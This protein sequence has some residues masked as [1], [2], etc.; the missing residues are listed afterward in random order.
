MHF[1][2]YPNI[3]CSYHKPGTVSGTWDTSV[4]KQKKLHLC[5][6]RAYILMKGNKTM[7]SNDNKQVN[8]L[9]QGLANSKGPN[10]KYFKFCN[11]YCL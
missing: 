3:Q 1:L 5:L 9:E 11:A 6:Y 7:N 8:Y 10:S 2:L 4:G